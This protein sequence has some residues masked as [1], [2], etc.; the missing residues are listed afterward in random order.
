MMGDPTRP[1]YAGQIQGPALG[2]DLCAYDE[3]GAPVVGKPGELVCRRPLPSMPLRFWNDDGDAKYVETYFSKYPGIWRH[4]D[5]IEITP[6]GGILVWGRSDATL[7]PG[8]VRIGTGE[9]Y[10]ALEDVPE[11]VEALAAGKEDGHDVAIW[12]FVV[13]RPGATLDRE[14]RQRLSNV[15]LKRTTAQHVPRRVVHVADL[16]RTHSG[17]VT[18]LA[19]THVINGRDIDNLAAIANPETLTALAIASGVRPLRER[20]ESPS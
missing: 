8:G 18:E 14:L 7:K 9:I 12:L 20:R 6:E 4:G 5:R 15:V 10:R 19:A 13:L 1:V 3:A 11:V 2:V 16:P 17:K